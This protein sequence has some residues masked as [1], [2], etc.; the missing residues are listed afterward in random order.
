MIGDRLGRITKA[1]FAQVLRVIFGCL[2]IFV[3][4]ETFS[5]FFSID[6]LAEARSAAVRGTAGNW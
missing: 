1:L 5:L 6:L 3:F 2:L 4:G